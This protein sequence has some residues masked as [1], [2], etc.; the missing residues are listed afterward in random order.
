V[1]VTVVESGGTKQPEEWRVRTLEVGSA[2]LFVI[3][4]LTT[5]ALWRQPFFQS[6][7]LYKAILIA[8]IAVGGLAAV[9]R[10][11]PFR[12]RTLMLLVAMLAVEIATFV[13]AGFVIGTAMSGLVLVFTAGLLLGVRW[14]VGAWVL[15][16]AVLMGGGALIATGRLATGF[17]PSVVDPR[18]IA[19]VMRFSL[20]YAGFTSVIAVGVSVLVSRLSAS[21]RETRAALDAAEASEHQRRAAA[22]AMVRAQKLEEIGRLTSGVAHDFNNALTVIS[23]WNSVLKSGRTDAAVLADAVAEIEHA[24]EHSAK[25]TRDLLSAGRREVHEPISLRPA[26]V[27]RAL[28][29]SLLKILPS[30]IEI[31]LDCGDTAPILADEVHLQQVLLNLVTNARDAMAGAGRLTIRVHEGAD[32]PG[33]VVIEVSDTG[34]GV[35]QTDLGTIFEPFFTTKPEGQGTG[36]G[37]AT[38]R[39]IVDQYGGDIAV[40]SRIGEGTCFRLTFPASAEATLEAVEPTEAPALAS[41]ATV[42]VADDDTHVR[43][44]MEGILA[45]AGCKV[46][47]ASSAREAIAVF[48]A[49]AGAIDLLVTDA[50][51]P[52]LGVRALLQHIEADW[53][54]TR[55]LVCSGYV[56]GELLRRGIEARRVPYLAKPFT[57]EQLL[58]KVA[59]ALR[60]PPASLDEPSG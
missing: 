7:P 17:D 18:D 29:D 52:G 21:L 45:T 51:M 40:E 14:A 35:E 42:L 25:L 23:G 3:G 50:V 16:T 53:P 43:Q 19:V 12:I 33:Y 49:H 13:R 11:G 26:D 15:T 55:F 48:D 28:G 60:A 57:R 44:V 6:A 5:A 27:I 2:C 1:A 4:C 38:V 37:L 34:H 24:C 32:P 46:L 10:S 8:G 41:G 56:E 20:V 9:W 59:K 22:D 58:G 36:L 30:D 47:T 31:E 39:H 54:G